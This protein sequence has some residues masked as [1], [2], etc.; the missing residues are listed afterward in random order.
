[1]KQQDW[2]LTSEDKLKS[3]PDRKLKQHVHQLEDHDPDDR[4]AS[5]VKK[6]WQHLQSTLH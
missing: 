4:P 6:Q 5:W 2:Q 3:P 1:M